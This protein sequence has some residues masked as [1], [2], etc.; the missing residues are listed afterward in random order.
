MG[1]IVPEN[2]IC[3]SCRWER[4]WVILSLGISAGALVSGSG[5][6]CSCRWG[7]SLLLSLLGAFVGALVDGNGRCCSHHCEW[8]LVAFVRSGHQWIL[9]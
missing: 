1:A 3:C 8:L 2:G 4:S 5:R 7:R 6:G 9:F